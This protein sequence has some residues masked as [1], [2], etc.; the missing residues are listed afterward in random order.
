VAF[1]DMERVLGLDETNAQYEAELERCLEL[2]RSSLSSFILG[3]RA[4]IEQLWSDLM[5]S[6]DETSAFGAFIDGTSH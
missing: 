4:E 5:L 1:F 2:R 6:E 3:A